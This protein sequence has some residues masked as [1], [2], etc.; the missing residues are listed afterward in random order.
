MVLKHHFGD[1]K[2]VKETIDVSIHAFHESDILFRVIRVL[3]Y[4]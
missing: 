4:F 1:A 2:L 3:S